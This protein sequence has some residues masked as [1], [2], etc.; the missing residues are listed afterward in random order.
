MRKILITGIGGDVACAIIRCLLEAF[1]E[2]EIYG[3]D[4]KKFTPYMHRIKEAI[5]AP[6]YT[7]SSYVQF[8]QDVIV[9]KQ[10]THFLPTTEQEILIALE[11]KTFFEAN[12]VKLVANN[13]NVV[14]TC[15]SKYK[16]MLFLSKIGLNVPLTYLATDEQCNNLSYPFIMKANYGSGGT[17]LTIIHN[18][19]QWEKADKDNMICQELIGDS[20]NE[21]TVGVF[22]D[23][24]ET[25]N[26]TFKRYLGP[27][28]MS[29]E[30][31]NCD[32][33]AITDIVKRIATAFALKGCINV[34]L[35]KQKERFFVFEINP[36]LSS[37]TGFRHKMGFQDAVWWLKMIDGNVIP[38]YKN[39][40]LK[41]IGVKVFDDVIVTPPPRVLFN[42]SNKIY[43]IL[44]HQEFFLQRRVA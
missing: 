31:H 20:E 3:M 10:I 18:K 7:Q 38:T 30:V 39:N 29:A 26:I 11:Q 25:R 33:Q 21:Y 37:T 4:I 24:S 44:L 2:D 28:G 14:R 40:H 35:R 41:S 8:L 22:A 1:P 6:R 17:K 9:Q 34:Q 32:I 23:G 12:N 5:I 36:R 43:N 15:T 42:K 13:E 16:T 27:G 19:E